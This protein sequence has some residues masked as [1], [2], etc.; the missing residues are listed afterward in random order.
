MNKN[1]YKT[2]QRFSRYIDRHLQPIKADKET[3]YLSKKCGVSIEDAEEF[4]SARETYYTRPCSD[5]EFLMEE[6][7]DLIADYLDYYPQFTMKKLSS[8]LYHSNMF[9]RGRN[10]EREKY[11]KYFPCT[12]SFI[13]IAPEKGGE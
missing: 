8:L 10:Y 12:T 13:E 9:R 1:D 3:F 11:R 4:L 5:S 6:E 7:L 2:S